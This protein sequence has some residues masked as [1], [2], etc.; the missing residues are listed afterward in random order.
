MQCDYF[1]SA[2][3]RS[4]TLMGTP[5][6]EQLA[7]KQ[8]T[9]QATLASV[10]PN[11]G[12][13]P[14]FAN[15]ESGFRNKAKLAVGGTI[16]APTLGI[17]DRQGAGVD[18]R[19]CGLYEPALAA[20]FPA[21]AEF[22]GTARLTPYDLGTRRGELKNLIVTQSPDGDV[23][24]RFVLRSQESIARIRKHLPALLAD[25]PQIVVVSANILPQHKAVLEGDLEIALSKPESLRMRVNDVVLHLRPRSFFQT[26]TAV[27]AGLYRQAQQWAGDVG[28]ARAW[29]LYCGVGG[30]ALHLARSGLPVVGVETSEEAVASARLSAFE[31]NLKD[32]SFVAADSAAY[33]ADHTAPG[34][35]VVN[36]PRRGIGDLAD[37]LQGSSATHVIYSSCNAESLARDLARMPS[38]HVEKARL[39]DMF[40]Q[41]SHHEVIVLL[42]RR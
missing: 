10:A 39:F 17:L 11:V 22:I 25:R 1:D 29:D 2:A 3:C 35:V 26:S 31:A 20:L 36:P 27:A 12:W 7:A 37:W 28:A 13:H 6:A 34:L 32:V 21:L 38:M 42:S 24:L 41:T 15:Q 16:H 5:Y 14:A 8:R 23:M 9:V 40:P 30:F 4:C 19:H 18:L 33:A